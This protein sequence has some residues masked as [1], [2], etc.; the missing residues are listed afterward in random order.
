[1]ASAS[2]INVV[3]KILTTLVEALKTGL[4]MTPSYKKKDRDQRYKMEQQRN[5][6]QMPTNRGS[7]K[8]TIKIELFCQGKPKEPFAKRGAINSRIGKLV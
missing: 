8:T 4:Q 6:M 1:V 2:C 5:S 3:L 7:I